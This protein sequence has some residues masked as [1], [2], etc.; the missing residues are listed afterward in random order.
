LIL[1]QQALL[2][3]QD[4]Q[5]LKERKAIQ[6]QQELREIKEIQEK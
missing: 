4:Q 1:V 6:V 3:E 2:G 5:A